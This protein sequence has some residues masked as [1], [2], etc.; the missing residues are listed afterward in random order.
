MA[1][2]DKSLLTRY[3]GKKQI[4]ALP[5]TRG[6]YNEFRGWTIPADENPDDAGYLVEYID[7]GKAN[8]ADFD[9]Y[10]SWS[11]IEVFDNAYKPCGTALER[12]LIERDELTEKVNK[13]TDFLAS[14]KAKQILDDN[15]YGLKNKQ[16]ITM[17][18]Y[19]AVLNDCIA[20]AK[21]VQQD[22]AKAEYD[23]TIQALEI[24]SSATLAKYNEL[25]LFLGRKDARTLVGNTQYDLMR[26]QQIRLKAYLE[27]L[28]NRINDYKV[29]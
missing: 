25:E 27:V 1:N 10:V 6:A 24:E 7:G 4:N 26:L 17:L 5:M 14:P 11:P 12:M 29:K 8:T 20:L 21:Q 2:L 9:G 15:M 28:R 13:L 18:D 23:N 19:L 22:K 3:E 16:L